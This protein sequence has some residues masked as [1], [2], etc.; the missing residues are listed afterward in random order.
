MSEP[1]VDPWLDSEPQSL[2]VAQIYSEYGAFL[3]KCLFRMGVLEADLPDAMQEV[4]LVVHR[5]KDSYDHTSKLSTWLF[6]I[7]LRVASTTRRARAR[8]REEHLDSDT[9]L[10]E[11]SEPSQLERRLYLRDAQRKLELILER[12][13]PEQRA[14]FTLYELD[15]VPC[16]R[17]AELLNV[18]L[19]TVHS[20]LAAVREQFKT[21]LERFNVRERSRFGGRS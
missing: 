9:T 15:N 1:V 6:G 5:R 10:N 3:W 13:E 2:T 14:L 19:G 4:L 20:R 21:E 12:L 18:P 8:R 11:T 16:Q 17:I 7:C